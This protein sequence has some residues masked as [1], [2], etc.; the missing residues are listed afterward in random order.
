MQ[1]IAIEKKWASKGTNI[2]LETLYGHLPEILFH[3]LVQ[4][5]RGQVVG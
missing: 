3:P 2:P 4:K 5:A 1:N